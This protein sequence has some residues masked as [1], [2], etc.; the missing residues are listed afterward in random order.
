LVP[1]ISI[2]LWIFPVYFGIVGYSVVPPTIAL[3]QN[4]FPLLVESAMGIPLL[5][6]SLGA[7]LGSA[8]GEYIFN[9]LGYYFVALLGCAALCFMTEC[10]LYYQTAHQSTRNKR[11]MLELPDCSTATAGAG[12]SASAE[13]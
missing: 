4:Y 12:A 7:A 13:A 9:T 2:F 5:L 11:A 3:C 6:H 10:T 8:L 1:E